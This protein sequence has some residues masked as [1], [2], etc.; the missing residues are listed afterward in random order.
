MT[1]ST[2]TAPTTAVTP[3]TFPSWSSDRC[4]CINP[5]WAALRQP[6]K[7]YE[8]H[9]TNDEC[10]QC[11]WLVQAI[12]TATATAT[13]TSSSFLP[14]SPLLCDHIQVDTLKGQALSR[15]SRMIY[16]LHQAGVKREG[17][18]SSKAKC[19]WFIQARKEQEAQLVKQHQKHMKEEAK[20]EARIRE[21]AR[22]AKKRSEGYTCRRCP[23]K[24]DS[25]TKLHVH[26]RGKH[27]KKFKS[28]YTIATPPSPP[29][30]P[31][32]EA[33]V[34]PSPSPPS[35]TSSE[36]LPPTSPL[37][38]SPPSSAA[39]PPTTPSLLAT[40]LL[41]PKPSR[42]PRPVN[43]PITTPLLEHQ[44]STRKSYMTVQDLY[45]MFHGRSRRDLGF[46]A[47]Q[48]RR[49]PQMRITNPRSLME[50]Q[51][52]NSKHSLTLDK[53]IL[54]NRKPAFPLRPIPEFLSH[55][56]YKMG[57][58]PGELSNAQFFNSEHSVAPANQRPP[59]ASTLHGRRLA[60]SPFSCSTFCSHCL[61]PFT[62]NN[63]LDYQP[64]MD[65]LSHYN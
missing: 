32:P 38:S 25:N 10:K 19:N 36:S 53:A 35:S 60:F 54:T 7:I 48:A 9:L 14:W 28:A 34:A 4:P 6:I 57:L 42:L 44:A 47:I 59:F 56:P 45:R 65:R 12:S 30:S 23:E 20:Q 52:S 58:I 63:G 2:S 41:T 5:A 61:R 17:L 21:E 31:N 15:D 39:T 1:T 3:P 55:S 27:A 50:L 13:V 49:P 64:S 43:R 18:T 26:I 24:F 11:D 37:I 16:E 40:K 33:S 29:V 8:E 22:I 46:P 62:F 51:R